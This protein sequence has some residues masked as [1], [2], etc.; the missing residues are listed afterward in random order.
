MALVLP[1]TASAATPLVDAVKSGNREAALT[2][3]TQR[4]DVNASE[5]D[6]TT[7]LHCATRHDL[8]SPALVRLLV[9]NGADAFRPDESGRS[10][11]QQAT[12]HGDLE[13]VAALRG[14]PGR[15]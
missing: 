14:E 15:R 8:G 2:L 1:S 5:P 11:M 6:G 4:V 10:A 3:I 13:L 12:T 7:A 9:A